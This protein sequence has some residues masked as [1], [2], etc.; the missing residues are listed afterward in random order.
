MVSENRM[1]WQFTPGH[2]EVWYATLSQRES[3]AGFWIRHTLQAPTEG[4]G[5]PTAR[6]WFAYFDPAGQKTFAINRRFDIGKLRH[7]LEPFSL[8]VGDSE[9]RSDGMR[10]ALEGAGRKVEWDLRWTPAS[11]TARILP[12]ASYLGGLTETKLLSPNL[13]VRASG[14]ITVDGERLVLKDDPLGQSHVWGRKHAYQWAWA[15]VQH[16]EC[17]V[18][19]LRVRLRRGH[20]LSPPLTFLLVKLGDRMIEFRELWQLPLVRGEHAVGHFAIE[21]TNL[22]WRIRVEIDAAPEALLMAEYVDPDGDAAYC[23]H[24]DCARAAV[25]IER[26]AGL[27]FVPHLSFD[28]SLAHVEW[29][30]RA[31]DPRVRLRHQALE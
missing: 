11:D 10:G 31:G 16:R 4:H 25:R 12:R 6:V 17:T 2:Y 20:F 21:A 23:H 13:D 3:G 24:T 1:R 5:V 15:H 7:Q 29:G 30:A 27:R 14:H 8:H 22:D 28:M 9:L 18:E 19:A 26:R